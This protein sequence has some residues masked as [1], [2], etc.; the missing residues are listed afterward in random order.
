MDLG[1][2][3]N[4]IKISALD[5]FSDTFLFT[6]ANH[7]DHEFLVSTRKFIVVS[8]SQRKETSRTRYIVTDAAWFNISVETIN[9]EHSQS[10]ANRNSMREWNVNQQRRLW[11]GKFCHVAYRPEILSVISA[12]DEG[13]PVFLFCLVTDRSI[14]WSTIVPPGD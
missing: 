14:A 4:I 8:S 11:P 1:L 9:D 5:T 2:E 13:Y 10:V 3:I 12:E 7:I 6:I